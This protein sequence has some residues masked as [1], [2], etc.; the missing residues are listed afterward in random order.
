MRVLS[1]FATLILFAGLAVWE[2]LPIQLAQQRN[3]TPTPTPVNT[4]TPAPKEGLLSKLLRVTGISATPS[5]MRGGGEDSTGD[6]WIVE[7]GANV[8]RRLTRNKGYKSPIFLDDRT[9]LALRGDDL[10]EVQIEDGR[11]RKLFSL[12]GPQKL[13]GINADNPRQ[14]LFLRAGAGDQVIVGLLSLDSGR[15]VALPYNPKSDLDQR[16]IAYLQGWSRSY[17]GGQIVLYL[18]KLTKQDSSGTVAWQDV[19]LE[20]TNAKPINVSRCN[21]ADCIQPSLSPNAGLVVFIK[22]SA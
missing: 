4:P 8:K 10:I 11:A 2:Q 7:L 13:V 17:N 20:R 5:A 18:E 9:V 6:V 22:A 12:E 16:T 3:P 14:A 19:F 1:F 21:G 15:V